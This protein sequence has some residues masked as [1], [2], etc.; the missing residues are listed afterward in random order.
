LWLTKD[1]ADYTEARKFELNNKISKTNYKKLYKKCTTRQKDNINNK[2]AHILNPQQWTTV[3]SEDVEP[4][5]IKAVVRMDGYKW[6][7]KGNQTRDDERYELY[8]FYSETGV[9]TVTTKRLS[10]RVL[11]DKENKILIQQYI[12]DIR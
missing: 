5:E 10:K 1:N 6:R 4:N 7:D 9:A 12:G 2:R 11:Y 3:I 8:Y